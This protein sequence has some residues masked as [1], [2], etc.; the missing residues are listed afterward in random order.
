MYKIGISGCTGKMGR[1]IC[2]E[3]LKQHSNMILVG[4]TA[5]AKSSF[6]GHDIGN[7]L[8]GKPIGVKILESSDEAFKD[9]DVIIDF[10]APTATEEAMEAALK[11]KI[12]MVIGTTGLGKDQRGALFKTSEKIPIVFSTN[13]S[14]GIA[15]LLEFVEE[16]ARQLGNT[17][18]IEI[19]DVHHRNKADAPSGT[20]ISLGKV[21]SKGRGIAL[22]EHAVRC[23]AHKRLPDEI[24]F[25][26]VRAG[27]MAGEHTVIFA[28]DY[29]MI[30]LNHRAFS[31]T[32]FANGAL[33]A[34][35]WVI[36]KA[37]G[38]YDMKNVLH[39]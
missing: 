13:T 24:G 7:M 35:T 16:A 28:D 14:V 23:R 29:E 30:S 26:S 18:D 1:T 37:P 20:A 2:L 17:F 6:I 9:A 34:A 31:R 12:P 21:A 33:R 32:V 36:D 5:R 25:S 15:L 11:H 19:I 8:N 27:D 10:S 39:S 4:G 22:D 38:L 3:V